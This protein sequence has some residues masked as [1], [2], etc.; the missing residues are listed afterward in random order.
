MQGTL[1]VKVNDKIGPYFCSYKGVRQ[2]DPFAPTL[3]N[4][5]VNSLSKMINMALQ[6]GLILGLADHI[7]DGGCSILQ[8]ADDTVLF[9]QDDVNSAINLKLLL[10]TFESM[11]GLKINFEKSEVLLIQ[12]DD[13][14]LQFY[15]DLFNCQSGNWPIKYLGT[16]VCHRRTT[17]A[18]MC[19]VGERIKKGT[20]GWMGNALSIG[21]RVTKIDACLSNSAVFRCP[22]VCYIKQI[23]IRWRNLS[24]LFCGLAVETGRNI[25]LSPGKSFVSQKSKGVWESKT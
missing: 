1:S 13:L 15:A 5:A 24:E 7:V 18:E 23:S 21:G 8:Y 6:N 11:S 12:S 3:F 4:I 2:G 22:Y 14:K 19:F 20:D 25:T 9:I 16:P 10:Y 17:V